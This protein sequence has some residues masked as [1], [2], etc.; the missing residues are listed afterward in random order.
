MFRSQNGVAKSI[1]KGRG[2]HYRCFGGL[3]LDKIRDC[4]K[5][6]NYI[7]PPLHNSM[8]FGINTRI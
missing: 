7:H 6:K 4:F 8:T 1:R 5:K 2:E 3:G